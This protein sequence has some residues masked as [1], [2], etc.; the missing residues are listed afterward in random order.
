MFA[1]LF[2][3][4]AHMLARNGR[5]YV[6][7]WLPLRH[8]PGSID[9]CNSRHLLEP[10]L[11]EWLAKP[12]ASVLGIS[13]IKN[14][15]ENRNS[16][17]LE[18]DRS[19]EGLPGTVDFEYD[20]C[21]DFYRYFL[22]F[23]DL[24]IAS[25]FRQLATQTILNEQE[26]CAYLLPEA[27]KAALEIGRAEKTLQWIREKNPTIVPHDLLD[28]ITAHAHTLTGNRSEALRYWEPR[29]SPKDRQYAD[30]LRG[31]SIA[32]VGPTSP[33][34]EPGKEID[35]F[36]IVVRTNF[37]N[38]RIPDARLFGSRTDVSYYN[39][40]TMQQNP[41]TISNAAG[42]LDWVNLK[43]PDAGIESSVSESNRA[44]G[45]RPFF[46]PEAI[47]QFGYPNAIP[48]ILHDLFAFQPGRIKLFGV[49]FFAS[50]NPYSA[51]YAQFTSDTASA[52]I[53]K[54]LRSHDPFSQF[55]FVNSMLRHQLISMDELGASVLD[56]SL[57]DYAANLQRI[58][59]S[60]WIDQ[61]H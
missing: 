24:A 57:A 32:I 40:S 50:A 17:L 3:Q 44:L 30:Y 60:L 9:F 48:C 20:E 33:E 35:S 4:A 1:R 5:R 26:Q 21:V 53:A 59:G 28:A 42:F 51:H 18:L 13:D 56:C 15:P 52:S 41:E 22:F 6:I 34:G 61:P 43:V 47:F 49:N 46:V 38:T 31:K 8:G 19:L 39:H 25:R 11:G 14:L 37:N 7:R 54:G 29:Y 58:Y 45:I 23:S 2:A 36:D 16:I 55:Y 27:L 10:L 12:T